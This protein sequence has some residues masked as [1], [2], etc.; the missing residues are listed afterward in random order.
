MTI[1]AQYMVLKFLFL[2]KINSLLN[3]LIANAI[4]YSD[5]GSKINLLIKQ[6][7]HFS[8]IYVCDNGIGIDSKDLSKIFDRFYRANKA[9][10][11][12]TQGTGLGLSLVKSIMNLHHGTVTI[13]SQTGK[14]TIVILRFPSKWAQ[15]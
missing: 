4:S 9:R 8:E 14:G 5:K 10:V 12:D 2:V 3:N 13:H 15:K 7:K 6:D 1:R 11:K